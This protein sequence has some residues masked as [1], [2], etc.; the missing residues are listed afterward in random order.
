MSCTGAF[1][2][3]SSDIAPEKFTPAYETPFTAQIELR[4][5]TEK[6]HEVQFSNKKIGYYFHS[7]QQ[8]YHHCRNEETHK[9]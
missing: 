9:Y 1:T 4:S 6:N 7:I 3:L 5:E 8:T 2:L